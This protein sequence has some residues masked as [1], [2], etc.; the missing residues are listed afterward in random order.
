[1]IE[2]PENWWVDAP[3]VSQITVTQGRWETDH[4]GHRW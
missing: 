3:G 4:D 2:T 1:M